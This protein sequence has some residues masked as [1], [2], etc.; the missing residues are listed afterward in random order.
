MSSKDIKRKY[1]NL[2]SNLRNYLWDYEAVSTIVD[3]EESCLKAFP[4]MKSVRRSSQKLYGLAKDAMR[5]DEDFK[6][7]FDEF[8]S[9]VEGND[10]EYML[11]AVN[12]KQ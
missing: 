9:C 10:C 7:S 12:V 3:L 8:R 6:R 5:D 11:I 4:D 1:I 2:Y